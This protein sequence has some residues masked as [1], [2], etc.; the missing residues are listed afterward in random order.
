[1][2]A[3]G[4]DFGTSSTDQFNLD[5]TDVTGDCSVVADVLSQSSANAT[6]KAGVIVRNSTSSSN[7]AFA[8]VV[9]TPGG[10][11]Q[12]LWRSGDG[13]TLGSST[14]SGQ[15]AP[16]WVRLSRSGNNFTA[17]YGTNGSTWTQIGSTQA[18]TINTAAFA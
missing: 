1:M 9:V 17:Y 6:A 14:V 11:V 8:A 10:G 15:T 3:G 5:T 18:V 2:T 4:A 7:A 12:F 13:G 16:L